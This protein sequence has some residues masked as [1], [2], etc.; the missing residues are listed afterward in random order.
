[1]RIKRITLGLICLLLSMLMIACGGGGGGGGGSS[2]TTPPADDSGSFTGTA[3]DPYIVGAVFEEVAADGV[4]VLQR[5]S[6][7]SN[8]QG[9]FTFSKSITPGSTISMK[10]GRKGLHQGTPYSGML[11]RAVVS[12]A[13]GLIISPLTTILANGVSEQELLQILSDAGITGLTANNLYADPVAALMGQSSQVT[14]QRLKLLHANMAINNLMEACEDFDLNSDDLNSQGIS[15]LLDELVDVNQDLFNETYFNQLAHDATMMGGNGQPLLFDDVI[16]P[17]VSAVQT[18]VALIKEQ[19]SLDNI[20]P[21]IIDNAVAG[22]QTHLDT[23]AMA[24]YEQRVD[25]VPPVT[26]DGADVF[27]ANCASCHTVNGSGGMD[28]SNDGSLANTKIT[29]GHMGINLASNE[30][31][32]LVTYVDSAV[33]TDPT[34]DPDPTPVPDPTPDPTPA[35]GQ[36][37]YD[38]QCAGCHS[39]GDYDTQGSPELSGSGPIL[40]AKINAGHRGVVLTSGEVS[41]VTVWVVNNTVTVPTPD[42]TPDPVP[43]PD[44]TAL[45]ESECQACHGQMN[46]NDIV[47]RSDVA[48]Q[49]A[50]DLNSGGMGSL[51]LT[52]DEITAIADAL[53]VAPTPDPVPVPDPDPIPLTGQELFDANCASCHS[54]GDYDTSGFAGDIG[55][56]GA[57][58]TTKIDAGHQGLSFTTNE[59]AALVDWANVNVAT[60]PVPDP[61]P[62]PDPVPVNGQALYDADC[63]SCHSLGDYDT[64]GFAADL[65]GNG[66]AIADKIIA[67]HQSISYTVDQLAAVVDWANAHVATPPDPTPDPVPVNG[68]TV[69]DDNCAACHSVNGYDATGYATDLASNSSNI[70]T[71]LAAGH[72]GIVLNNEEQTELGTFVDQ[73]E[74]VATGPDYSDCMACHD[75]PP[76]TGSH[77]VHNALAGVDCTSCHAGAEHNGQLELE[78]S[79]SFNSKNSFASYNG[80]GNCSNISCHGGQTTPD[81]D[82]GSLV[83]DTQCQ[84]CHSRG[85]GEFNSYDSGKHDKHVRDKGYNCNACHSTS[86]LSPGHFADLATASFGTDP[87]TTVGGSSTATGSYNGSTCSS[88]QCHGSE[89]W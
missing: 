34:P 41:A 70:S 35:N 7:P 47:D 82:S 56:N 26:V 51:V 22:A 3:V 39:L 78:F 66:V 29:Q 74:A 17:M 50:I 49:D 81:W 11:R 79:S 36:A 18:I 57:G 42:P 83:V 28:L 72:Q 1:M 24:E 46:N 88:V 54:L 89:R 2:S 43:V 75:Q 33:P 38:N 5:E 16:K 40:T 6:T 32:A 30:L 60:P 65:G 13:D 62:D 20:D 45:Y 37:L 73:Y 55:G 87:A 53:P 76:T 27:A 69:Y 86:K 21:T 67:G 59:L 15:S 10:I 71:K 25:V 23:A 52:A 8:N 63:A 14:D 80:N 68:Q 19:P 31:Q 58:I 84:S 64:T 9:Q 61:I 85:T 44:G 4:T 77:V 48:I 12:D